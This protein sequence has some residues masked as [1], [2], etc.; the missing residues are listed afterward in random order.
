MISEN[1]EAEA[2]LSALQHFA[3][4]RRQWG[5]IFVERQWAENARTAEGQVFHQTAHH[6]PESEARG[7]LLILRGLRVASPALRLG[8]VCDVVEFH[9]SPSGVP[10]MGREGFWLPYPVEYKKGSDQTRESDEVQLCGQALCLEDMLC[11]QIP[12]GSLFY[13]ETRRRTRVA[14]DEPLRQRTFS[15]LQEMLGHMA[16]GHTPAAKPHKGCNACSLRDVCLP[17]LSRT[18]SVADYVHARAAEENE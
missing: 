15:L 4:C 13:G 8:G 6:G 3:Y 14:F 18:P 11:C 2:T 5:L 16:R 1:R 10:L 7:D 9:R 12:E 17:K